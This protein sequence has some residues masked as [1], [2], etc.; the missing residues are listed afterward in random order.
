MHSESLS[1]SLTS[2]AF[3]PTKAIIFGF[4]VLFFY[5]LVEILAKAIPVSLCLVNIKLFETLFRFR[6]ILFRLADLYGL[7]LV[8]AFEKPLKKSLFCAE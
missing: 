8:S 2:T 1:I 4:F 3:V 7:L 5:F 6:H